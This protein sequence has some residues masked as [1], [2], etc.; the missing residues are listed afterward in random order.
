MIYNS[1]FVSYRKKMYRKIASNTLAQ[2]VSKMMTAIISI[3]LIG[4][5]TKYLPIEQYGAYN[6]VYNYLGIFAFLADLWLYAITIREISKQ[7][8][9][10]EK[11]MGNV[12]S[13]RIV[14]GIFVVAFA[15]C[16]AFFLPAY[17]DPLL[18]I[19]LSI[20]GIFT[21]VS[22]INSALLAY[23]QSQL[24]MEFSLISLVAGKLLNLWAVA[25]FLML[26][27]SA[28]W[29]ENLAFESVFIAA[30]AG[31]FLNTLLNYFYV[32]KS[33]TLRPL[34]DKEYITH[35]S[36]IALPYGIALFLSVVYFKVDIILLSFLEAQEKA[37]ISIAL[38]S[39]PMKI[40][41]VLMV[42][43]GFYLNSLLPTL[44]QKFQKGEKKSL[45][46]LYFISLK[47]LFSFGVLIFFLWNL[48]AVQTLSIISTPEYINPTN[49]IYSSVDAFRLSL[50]VL[51]FN[52]MA[53]VSI[54]MLIAAE[55]QSLLLWING[56]VTLF[57][58]VGNILLIPKYSFIGAAVITVISQI[59]L[60][61]LTSFMIRKDINFSLKELWILAISPILW[62]LLYIVGQH[63]L[64]GNNWPAIMQ[65][66]LIAPLILG[67]Y[68]IG[69]FMCFKKF[70]SIKSLESPYW[71]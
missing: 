66:A 29:A 14:L 23:M 22:L 51:M 62:I 71:N 21:I 8:K 3:V 63:I 54:Y 53:N 32:S 20:I 68:V 36:K 27:F 15:L 50:A 60:F 33:I 44:T 19:A 25:L 56:G 55:R 13:L 30:L 9:D 28:P 11:I 45:S 41:E 59:L 16:V 48:F 47:L 46:Q 24:K 43:W 5:L 12:L 18:L 10:T 17:N 35:I 40:V 64:T 70:T 52:F 7:P 1:L 38:Y 61:A 69:D 2:I 37:D 67:I 6:K 31:I 4:I 49:H 65:I 34:W 26:I 58:I 39:L 57:N 42:L